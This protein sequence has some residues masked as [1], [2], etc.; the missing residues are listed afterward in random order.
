MP[1]KILL[2][3]LNYCL[4]SSVKASCSSKSRLSFCVWSSKSVM[5]LRTCLCTFARL[6]M[7]IGQ[8]CCD[9]ELG[10]SSRRLNTSY[11]LFSGYCALSASVRYPIQIPTT[12]SLWVFKFVIPL[13][14]L[15]LLLK[16]R[17]LT[18]LAPLP[19]WVVWIFWEFCSDFS[20][21]RFVAVLFLSKSGF[22]FVSVSEIPKIAFSKLST[23]SV[24]IAS[25]IVSYS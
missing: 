4:A 2:Q 15:L 24:N 12:Y 22:Y 14:S 21:P 5:R 18:W 7:K 9:I 1:V 6:L 23:R 25:S 17:S 20:F 19:P 10:L 11:I 3:S 13:A 16:L 8:S